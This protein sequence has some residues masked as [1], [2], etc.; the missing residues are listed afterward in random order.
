[1]VPYRLLHFHQLHS[2]SVYRTTKIDGS[3]NKRFKRKISRVFLEWCNLLQL[4]FGEWGAIL[5]A[6]AGRTMAPSV[7]D[8]VFILVGRARRVIIQHCK[9]WENEY[10]I[11]LLCW[12]N[13]TGR[14]N[15]LHFISYVLPIALY[16]NPCPP[17]PVARSFKRKYSLVEPHH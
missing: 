8:A 1:M 16:F 9:W 5:Q 14:K 13:F 7:S 4:T 12:Y 2:I 17:P 15:G 11:Y 10:E 3:Q 6:V